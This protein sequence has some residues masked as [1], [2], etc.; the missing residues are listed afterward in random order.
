[1]LKLEY[2]SWSFVCLIFA[3]TTITMSSIVLEALRRSCSVGDE[4]RR[5]KTVAFRVR[6]NGLSEVGGMGIEKVTLK[7]SCESTEEILVTSSSRVPEYVGGGTF[8]VHL[9]D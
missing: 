3:L 2:Y 8:S 5:V 1:M 7:V 6:S 4:R 9:P